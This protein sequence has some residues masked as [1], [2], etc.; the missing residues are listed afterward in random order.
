MSVGALCLLGWRGGWGTWDGCGVSDRSL[1]QNEAN[2]TVVLE[3]YQGYCA[4]HPS[5]V[6]WLW[7]SATSARFGYEAYLKWIPGSLCEVGQEK[8]HPWPSI[9]RI[10]QGRSTTPCSHS[11]NLC[12]G[13]ILSVHRREMDARPS[14]VRS[15]RAYI[16][17]SEQLLYVIDLCW[18]VSR[19]LFQP[20][21]GSAPATSKG[22]T[23][24][25]GMKI[26]SNSTTINWQ[27]CQRYLQDLHTVSLT[28]EPSSY[29]PLKHCFRRLNLFDLSYLLPVQTS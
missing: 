4:F 11:W 18:L 15:S 22:L 28:D 6:S 24:T 23:K 8:L 12:T 26:Q 13:W 27:P 17:P 19:F 1:T 2:I 7:R 29:I 3:H 25:P 14:N 9:T 20:L 21:C 5:A 16:W 10:Q